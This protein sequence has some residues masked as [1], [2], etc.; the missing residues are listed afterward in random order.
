MSPRE[1]YGHREFENQELSSGRLHDA[2]T[3]SMYQ[4]RS[5]PVPDTLPLVVL[6]E[7]KSGT[8][9]I[10]NS[11][12][13][14]GSPFQAG[15]GASVTSPHSVLLP[16]EEGLP[17]FVC[18]GELQLLCAFLQVDFQLA[19]VNQTLMEVPDSVGL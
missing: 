4:R 10:V 8:W 11:G 6:R 17:R 2:F 5:L 16:V 3:L 14:V 19:P 7:K 13:S 15:A 12:A 18:W 9:I 1:P